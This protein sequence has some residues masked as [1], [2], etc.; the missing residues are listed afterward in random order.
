MYKRDPKAAWGW[1]VTCLLIPTLGPVIYF[2]LGINRIRTRAKKLKSELPVNA[3]KSVSFSGEQSAQPFEGF[4]NDPDLACMDNISRDLSGL[5]LVDGNDVQI[6]LNGNEAY[7]AMLHDIGRAKQYV[8]LATYIFETNKTGLLF[9]EALSRAH[10]RGVDVRVMLDGI[11]EYYSWPSVGR[12]LKKA[13]IPFVRFLPPRL[14]PLSPFINLR[15]HRKM[16]IID[17]E[18]G[19]TGGM[20]LGDRHIFDEKNAAGVQDI[21][22]KFKGPVVSQMEE[23]FMEDWAF[24]TGSHIDKKTKIAYAGRYGSAV[25]R[26]FAIGPNQD[27]DKLR[28]LYTGMISQARKSIHIMTPYFLPSQEIVGALQAAAL[29]GLDINIVL[30]AVN[31]LPFVHWATRNMLWEILQYGIKV[32]YQ[33]APFTHSKLFLIDDE[34]SLVG[35]ANMDPR[36]IR[37][38]F[39][40]VVEV[41]SKY[42]CARLKKHFHEK[43]ARSEQVCLLDVDSRTISARLRDSMCWL[44]TPYL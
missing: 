40:I 10:K 14:I 27:K 3:E 23:I 9:V 6:F 41:Y 39:E 38:N 35:S 15:N 5:N 16:L 13:Q 19:F 1:I 22:F 28:I 7:P 30:P 12:Y 31:N 18:T 4:Q 25:C 8:F 33:P 20:N 17:G 24:S 32:Y 26:T 43:I 2:L 29:K 44:F 36:S 21:Q 11:G 37:L 34:Y 42:L